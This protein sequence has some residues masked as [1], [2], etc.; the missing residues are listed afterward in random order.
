[1]SYHAPKLEPVV[2]KQVNE[3]LI[4]FTVNEHESICIASEV[5]GILS[6]LNIKVGIYI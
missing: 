6:I 5:S 4:V 2:Q 3:K 1:M